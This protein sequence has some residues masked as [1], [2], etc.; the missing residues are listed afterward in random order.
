MT[1]GIRAGDQNQLE[2]NRCVLHARSQREDGV[3]PFRQGPNPGAEFT[4]PVAD[5][6]DG[7][8]WIVLG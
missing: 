3:Q 8:P 7:E 6:N 2:R 4:G 5:Q 1:C